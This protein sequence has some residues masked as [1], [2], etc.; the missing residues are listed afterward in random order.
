MNENNINN[1]TIIDA[2]ESNFN[3]LVLEASKTKLIIAD[4]WAPWCGPCKQ[5]TPILEKII[6]KI[7]DK[8]TLAKINIDENQQIA[9]QLRIQSIP[10]VFAFKN[11]APIDAFQGVIPENK[12]IE[13]IEKSLGEKIEKD[14]SEF[15]DL[16]NN[17][18]NQTDFKQAL[19]LIEEFMVDNENEN[20]AKGL[21]LECLTLLK[22]FDEAQSFYESLDEETT[23]NKYIESSFQKL[24]II[25]KNN[26]GPPLIDLQNKL[27]KNPKDIDVICEL[28]DKYF[29]EN[30]IDQAFLLLLENYLKNKEKIKDKF[31]EFFNALGNNHEKTNEYRKKLSS[32]MFS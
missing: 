1:K 24:K 31:I 29:A 11:S 14:H 10:A 3:D 28:A 22:N 6:N 23:K 19:N 9:A 21:Y 7:G 18:F 15:Y 17:L 12:I 27:K 5:L 26:S 2:N 20:K 30:Q 13:F 4:F 32:I 16:I 25:K 8:V